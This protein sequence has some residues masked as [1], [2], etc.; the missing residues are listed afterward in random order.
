MLADTP[1]FV[2]Q[3]MAHI[4]EYLRTSPPPTINPTRPLLA[5][6]P[7]PSHL[8]LNPILYLTLAIDSVAPLIRVARYSG[9]LGGGHAMDVPLPLRVRQRRRIAFQWILDAVEKKPSRGSGRKQF[10][11]RVAEE[12]V[13]VAE[14]RSAVWNKRMEVH[15]TGTAA[16]ANLSNRALKL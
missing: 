11:Y 12:I 4:L 16:R 15:K 8:P 6:A 9:I 3:D 14:G 5:G 7:P 2:V 1:C 13:A 10:P